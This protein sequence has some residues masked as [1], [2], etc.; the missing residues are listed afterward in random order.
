MDCFLEK[1]WFDRSINFTMPNLLI[2]IVFGKIK[3]PPWRIKKTN[4]YPG[5]K[6]K[7]IW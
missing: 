3:N 5:Q 6:Q 2:V 4:N 7:K 1:K